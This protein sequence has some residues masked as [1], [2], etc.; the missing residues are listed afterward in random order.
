MEKS[1]IIKDAC[2]FV[3]FPIFSHVQL[4]DHGKTPEKFHY[5][6]RMFQLPNKC[7]RVA[8]EKEFSPEKETSYAKRFDLETLKFQ[9]W[10]TLFRT[11]TTQ[12]GTWI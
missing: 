12:L 11:T 7:S 10:R 6:S 4:P 3:V 8:M 2:F 1:S 5:I 9:R